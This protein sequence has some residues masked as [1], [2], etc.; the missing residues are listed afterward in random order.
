MYG[1]KVCWTASSGRAP[2]S[3][4]NT[5]ASHSWLWPQSEF[6]LGDVKNGT[7]PAVFMVG[8]LIASLVYSE[9]TKTYNAFRLIG[10]AFS[11]LDTWRCAAPRHYTKEMGSS[12]TAEGL[13]LHMPSSAC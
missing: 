1:Q 10:E 4:F 8:L 2:E 11:S 13:L 5:K 7:L 6:K 12:T 9:L 3:L